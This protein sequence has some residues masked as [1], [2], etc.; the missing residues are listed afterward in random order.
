M[1]LHT[2]RKMAMGGL[3]DHLGGGFHRYSVDA[4]WHVPHF[5]KM[6]YD[7]WQLVCT[8]LDAYQATRDPFFADVARGILEYVRRDM[9]GEQGQFYSAEDADSPR[10]ANADE[11]AEGAF[12]VWTWAELAETLG[13]EA[14]E[15][16]AFVYGVEP[17]GNVRDAPHG[18]LRGRNV[19]ILSRS[20]AEA[21][22]RF[23]MPEGAVRDRLAAARRR[24]FETRAR[25]PRPRRDDKTI[26]AWNGLM[27][28][29]FARA[30]QALGDA[31]YLT[32]AGRAADFIRA[33]L[34]DESRGVLL[35]RYRA[36]PSAIDGYADDYAFL[37]RGLLDLYEAGFDV[38]HVE[39]ALALQNRQDA[40][41]WDERDGGYFDTSGADET[42]LLRMKEGCATLTYV[43]GHGTEYA[44]DGR[45]K[46]VIEGADFA[47]AYFKV[48]LGRRP[49][50]R[51]V[52]EQLL[53]GLTRPGK[54]TL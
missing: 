44:L 21:A 50:S 25:R 13:A 5:E 42:I 37:I 43:P 16:F 38:A 39:W 46:A 1:A 45:V 17:D 3:H 28:S 30:H 35:R 32:A 53:N 54:E 6:L 29:A 51:S 41:F 8:Y 9:T 33:N 19:L 34:Y 4:R 24:L 40:L 23:R 11:S 26:T 7:Q 14:A 49:G 36:G 31:A 20:E 10:D 48:W 22:A 12:Y 52:K 27:I 47:S 2:L 15:M 18:E